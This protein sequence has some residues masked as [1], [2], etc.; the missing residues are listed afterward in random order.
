MFYSSSPATT[1]DTMPSYYLPDGTTA[2]VTNLTPSVDKEYV[3]NRTGIA[4]YSS[5]P[6]YWK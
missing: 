5:L 1:A 4:G 3:Y 2:P 6:V